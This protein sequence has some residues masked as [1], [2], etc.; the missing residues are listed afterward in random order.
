MGFGV[1]FERQLIFFQ[2]NFPSTNLFAMIKNVLMSQVAI[3]VN[4]AE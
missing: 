3:G 2:T 1:A 4:N